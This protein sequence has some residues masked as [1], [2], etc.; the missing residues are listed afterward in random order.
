MNYQLCLQ[1]ITLIRLNEINR[2][3][4]LIMAHEAQFLSR[5]NNSKIEKMSCH[6]CF[7]KPICEVS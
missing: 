3:M 4:K 6:F 2:S 1:H 5:A 7:D